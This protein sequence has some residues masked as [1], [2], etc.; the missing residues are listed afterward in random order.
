MRI[1]RLR[2]FVKSSFP[3]VLQGMMTPMN[4]HK[5][6]SSLFLSLVLAAIVSLNPGASV[7]QEPEAT[8]GAKAPLQLW[9]KA[10][11]ILVSH[12]EADQSKQSRSRDQAKK[13][14]ERIHSL[15]S[16]KT[17]SESFA[18]LAK[19][20]SDA[21]DKEAGGLLP[22]L[23]AQNLEEAA[24][25]ALSQLSPGQYSAP[26][27]TRFGFHIFFREESKEYGLEQRLFRYKGAERCPESETQTKAEAQAAAAK[28]LKSLSKPEELKG[29]I[30][31]LVVPSMIAKEVA[32][33]LVTLKPGEL[34]REVIE[35]EFGFHLIRRVPIQ[36]ASASH[37]LIDHELGF[38]S[39]SLRTKDEA[40]QV[41]EQ[42][43]AELKKDPKRFLEL[44]K[45]H[46]ADKR[47]SLGV[48]PSKGPQALKA[49]QEALFELEAGA[50]LGRVVE[51]RYG[52][53]IV[54][55]QR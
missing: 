46:S 26:V 2:S 17:K 11:H 7:A 44:H 55:R 42:V 24:A 31:G 8:K 16:S 9:L 33:V 35:S 47:A 45:Q 22:P 25:T 39:V 19:K 1:Q 32:R 12:G 18:A 38:Q 43:L 30:L 23:R 28:A 4:T 10:R 3:R 52:F 15:L 27:E 13:R 34:H 49:I 54:L 29:E 40:K 41:A 37:I 36:V 21:P 53:H 51:S 50:V 48:I 14:I 20:V 5:I 6:Q